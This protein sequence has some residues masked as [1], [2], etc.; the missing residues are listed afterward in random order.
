MKSSLR[1]R[2]TRKSSKKGSYHKKI[3]IPGQDSQ[4]VKLKKKVIHKEVIITLKERR[5]G[6]KRDK[7]WENEYHVEKEL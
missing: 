4:G 2:T 6:G 1:D 7:V 3:I 5:P